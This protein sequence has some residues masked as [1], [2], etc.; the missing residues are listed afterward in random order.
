MPNINL[1]SE[2]VSKNYSNP[3]GKSLSFSIAVLILTILLYGGFIIAN[4]VLSSKIKTVQGE[5]TAEYNKFLSGNGNE[6]IDFKNRSEAAGKMIAE[7]K[8]TA[9]IL[10][11]IE[12]SMLPS[13]YINS[14]EY[15]KSSQ[16]VT[17]Q[18]IGDNFTTVA[19]Q[20]LSFKQNDFFAAVVPGRSFLDSKN[21]NKLS[22]YIDL[23]IK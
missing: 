21:S 23:K 10:S 2:D 7:N 1:A 22:F 19:K 12:S 20:I 4:G 14:L 8:S 13:V 5:Y 18:C 6:I 9:D 15:N 11:R 17:L 3:A 16:T